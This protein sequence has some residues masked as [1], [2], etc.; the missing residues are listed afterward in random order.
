MYAF[1]N[2]SEVSISAVTS[3]TIA[4]FPVPGGPLTYI[5]PPDV[6]AIWSWMKEFNSCFSSCLP[7]SFPG[8]E[9]LVNSC[10][11]RLYTVAIDPPGVTGVRGVLGVS[12]FP[13]IVTR[14]RGVT[15][16][17][18]ESASLCLGVWGVGIWTQF[19]FSSAT[20]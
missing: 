7:T 17:F 1:F 14:C 3:L 12:A 5:Q 2:T 20:G 13:T 9:L 10:R 11:A 18:F 4:L 16:A 8:S 6:L 19:E 15:G